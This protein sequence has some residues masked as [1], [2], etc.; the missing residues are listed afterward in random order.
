MH[1]LQGEFINTCGSVLAV[2]MQNKTATIKIDAKDGLKRPVLFFN[3]P[4]MTCA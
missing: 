4:L 1:I 2:D 3:F